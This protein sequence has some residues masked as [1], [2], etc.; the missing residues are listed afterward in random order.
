M[1]CLGTLVKNWQSY[2][3]PVPPGL[4]RPRNAEPAIVGK[5]LRMQRFPWSNLNERHLLHEL[6][7]LGLPCSHKSDRTT[8]FCLG[9]PGLRLG[10]FHGN[11]MP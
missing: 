8:G 4:G 2:V 6:S 7:G 9:I 5:L 1:N 10:V 3:G 11:L